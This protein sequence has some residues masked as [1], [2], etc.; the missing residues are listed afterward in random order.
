MKYNWN[1]AKAFLDT[2]IGCFGGDLLGIILYR[3]A[4]LKEESENTIS[5]NCLVLVAA[6]TTIEVQNGFRGLLSTQFP[7]QLIPVEIVDYP[8][9]IQKIQD[10]DPATHLF[11]QRGQLL[12][13]NDGVV[14]RLRESAVDP[15]IMA[16]ANIEEYLIRKGRD[17][18]RNIRPL[19]VRMLNEIY[20]MGSSFLAYNILTQNQNEYDDLVKVAEWESLRSLA[21]S[22]GCNEEDIGRLDS[23]IGDLRSLMLANTSPK[24]VIGQ[25]LLDLADHLLYNLHNLMLYSQQD[26]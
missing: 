18:W 25:D 17:H 15:S 21:T 22:S 20:L 12:Y 14:A 13:D 24:A 19:L 9:V 10:C 8:N 26:D 7:E 3:P 16:R 11:L 5:P 4:W 1:K 23:V 2:A 6:R